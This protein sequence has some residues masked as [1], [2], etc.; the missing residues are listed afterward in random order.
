MQK[1]FICWNFI[2]TVFLNS[3]YLSPELLENN[4]CEPPSDLWALGCIIYQLYYGRT[5]FFD[6]QEFIVFEKIK[7]IEYEIPPNA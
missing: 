3:S 2:V 7:K 5:P 1:I 4:M 6:K